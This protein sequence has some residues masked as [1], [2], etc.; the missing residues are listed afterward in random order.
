MTKEKGSNTPRKKE[1]KARMKI[2]Y[3]EGNWKV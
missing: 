3:V 1:V 2:N